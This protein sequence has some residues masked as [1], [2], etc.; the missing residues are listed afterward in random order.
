MDNL[1]TVRTWPDR[2][3]IRRRR[4]LLGLPCGI[5]RGEDDVGAQAKG[6]CNL[7][8]RPSAS[9]LSADVDLARVDGMQAQLPQ[10]LPFRS[11]QIPQGHGWNIGKA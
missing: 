11:C 7:I 4:A 10:G 2:R 8:D 1:R 9:P 3:R 6:G 5:A